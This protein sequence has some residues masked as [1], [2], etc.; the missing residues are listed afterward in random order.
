MSAEV[1]A[2][3][4]LSTAE[5]A[6]EQRCEDQLAH[7]WLNG[8][9]RSELVDRAVTQIMRELREGGLGESAERFLSSFKVGRKALVI[10][11][12]AHKLAQRLI[13]D[14]NDPIARRLFA[15]VARSNRLTAEQKAIIKRVQ[16]Q[17]VGSAAGERRRAAG[18]P[19]LLKCAKPAAISQRQR[20]P[21]QPKTK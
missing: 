20:A 6:Y 15:K 1:V 9:P 21:K 18:I 4:R 10:A 8:C 3:R 14:P 2:L 11:T 13:A 7:D 17:C 16:S 5:A 12:E 19:P